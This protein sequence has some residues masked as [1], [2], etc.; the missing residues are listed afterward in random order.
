VPTCYRTAAA[1]RKW[2]GER[3]TR[4]ASAER[5]TTTDSPTPSR[6][7]DRR[8]GWGRSASPSFPSPLI[9]PDVRIP[10]IWLSDWFHL[11]TVGGAPMYIRRCVTFMASCKA[12][13][14]FTRVTACRF[15]QPPKGGL[16]HEASA[17]PV[18]RSGLRQLPGWVLSSTGEPRRWGA[19]ND[20]GY[21]RAYDSVAEARAL[22]GRYL[23]FYKP[24]RT[25][26]RPDTCRWR[27][28]YEFRRQRAASLRSGY[29]LPA[30]RPALGSNGNN[31]RRSIYRGRNVVQTNPTTSI[32]P[33]QGTILECVGQALR[34][35]RIPQA[36]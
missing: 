27:R 22:L 1:C 11:A 10:C 23:A 35:C 34:I 9:K 13:S 6:V 31:C 5:L 7:E 21:L 25:H 12:C 15:A 29:A 8:S 3:L 17:R 2:L 36:H 18:A 30:R 16:C 14:G 32:P 24:G 33:G 28:L 4:L 20:P 19:L 26:A